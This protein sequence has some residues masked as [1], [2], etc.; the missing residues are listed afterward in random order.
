MLSWD[1]EEEE[2][3]KGYDIICGIDEAGRGPLAGPVYAAAV[4]LPF[5]TVIEGLDDSKKL[6]E[7]KREYLFDV[8]TEKALAYSISFADVEEID[9]LNIL[10]ATYLAMK[11][12][13]DGLKLSPK[14]ILVDGNSSK[15]LTIPFRC[16]IKGDAKSPNIAAA[17]I[18]AKV[19]RDRYITE[20][21]A[22]YPVYNLK[23]H[24]GYGTKE[25]IEAIL[26]YGPCELHRK[27][28]LKNILENQEDSNDGKEQKRRFR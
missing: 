27:T 4:I 24:K 10:N 1:I 26:K 28:F 14:L 22:V 9:R 19:S 20:Q 6:T 8:I 5:G 11:R 25:H 12:A 15:G 7:K 3:L 16:V 13:A 18:L 23:K 17:S 2:K 21:D